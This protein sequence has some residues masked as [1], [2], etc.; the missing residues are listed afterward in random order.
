MGAIYLR[1]D[2]SQRHRW[3]AEARRVGITITDLIK[4]AVDERIAAAAGDP[5]TPDTQGVDGAHISVAHGSSIVTAV[6]I[7]GSDASVWAGT[8]TAARALA[9]SLLYQAAAAEVL[10]PCPAV[11]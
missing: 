2:D 9:A 6:T 10:K 3:V 8:P 11:P 5:R 7:R 4:A 1:I